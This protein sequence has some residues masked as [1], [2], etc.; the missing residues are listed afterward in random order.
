MMAGA[1]W[2][3][4]G[5]ETPMPDD[6]PDSTPRERERQIHRVLEECLRRRSS[7][8]AFADEEVIAA[9]PA[10]MP[11]LGRELR[12]LSV[13]RAANRSREAAGKSDASGAATGAAGGAEP[14]PRIAGYD[15]LDEVHRGGQ[16]V[17]F[18]ALQR[19]T[20]REVAIKVMREG[21]FAGRHDLARF[22][23]EVQTLARLNHPNIVNIHD[24]G[25]ADGRHYFVMDYIDGW[26]LDD[27]LGLA[28]AAGPR[29]VNGSLATATGAERTSVT[30]DL[31]ASRPGEPART[32]LSLA[33]RLSLFVT[34]CEAVQAAH[35]RGVIHR[36]L[37]PSNIR[38]DRAGRPH[39]LDF[40]LAKA[41]PSDE[42]G[43]ASI[44]TETGQF[45][46]S[47]PWAA[48][49]QAAGRGDAVDM[50]T[51]VY[52]LGVIL[53]EMLTGRFPYGVFGPHGDVLERIR[54]AEPVRPS[55]IRSDLDNDVET[56]VLKCLA[57]EPDRRYQTAGELSRDVRRYL[58]G[59]PIDAKRDSTWYV[60]RKTARRYRAALAVMSLI[61]ALT[62]VSAVALAVMYRRQTVA[63]EAADA[64]T[65]AESVARRQAEAIN[66]FLTGMIASANVNLANRPDVTVREVLD[67]A[68]ARIG[69]D[70]ASEPLIEASVR[71]TLGRAYESIGRYGDASAHA[72]AALALLRTAYRDDHADIADT[73]AEIAM[74]QYRTGDPIA[75]EVTIREAMDIRRR[76]VGEDHPA[77]AEGRSDLGF[78]LLKQDRFDEAEAAL[79][80]AE[81]TFAAHGVFDAESV[82]NLGT[83]GLVMRKRGD[84]AAAAETLRSVVQQWRAL[85][86]D[87]S[88]RVAGALLNLGSALEDLGQYDEAEAV[89]GESLAMRRRVL[90]EDHLDVA[91]SLNDL[92][93]IRFARGDLEGAGQ[94]LHEALAI[95]ESRLEPLH[96]DIFNLRY[97]L[98]SLYTQ[99]GRYA[100]AA[101]LFTAM[102]DDAERLFGPESL[103]VAQ[104][105][106]NYALML[107]DSG[108]LDAA[109][110]QLRSAL[111]I[112]RQQL[113]DRHPEVGDYANNLGSILRDMDRLD[114][115][116]P[117][118]R[119]GLEIR[120]AAYE[121]DH[122]QIANSLSNIAMLMLK[123][124]DPA[125]AE[126]LL[127]EAMEIR[128]RALPGHWLYYSTVG[129]LGETLVLLQRYEEAEA[130]LL[131]AAGFHDA[132]PDA[133][134]GLQELAHER[135]VKLYE[136]WC[137]PGD[138]ERWRPAEEG[139]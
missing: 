2:F 93:G 12:L 113:G 13:M 33:E 127:R 110:R 94:L 74:I 114:E 56:I 91:S 128:G 16:G 53:Y 86:G 70:L 126:P 47:L 134:V 80:A 20:R 98:A 100:E 14:F 36:D 26:P 51:D 1:A 40:G 67:R 96:P 102:L 58:A 88:A 84:F 83:L 59:E 132:N 120:R 130:L 39:L 57:K 7:G 92:A 19:S 111:L 107:Q 54:N 30:S 52:A 3:S 125:G 112:A 122:P 78:Y 34:V 35:V 38:V 50:R 108:D 46:G 10:L 123:R 73:L 95:K 139:R 28:G 133:R 62:S 118:L 89:I 5:T 43:P 55:R 8:E 44:V 76:L 42:S 124:D 41:M 87:D 23:R 64:A 61:V 115:A 9:Y 65:T 68:A 106:A 129:R 17:V 15:I 60:L 18:R 116:E 117:L 69:T 25:S 99:S 49:E 6:L 136:A 48:P 105:A 82:A 45:V 138:A 31:S 103:Q 4:A 21:P 11:E 27:Y 22:E 24:R 72:T 109:E 77:F 97:N 71:R 101:P 137:R 29:A 75:A 135:L 66:A 81:A 63:R 37:K 32:P 90:G 104:I 131:E 79:R 85:D 121:P 119:E